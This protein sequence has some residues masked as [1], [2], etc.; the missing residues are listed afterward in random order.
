M[1]ILDKIKTVVIVILE[2][3][4]FDHMLG[5]LALPP[6]SRPA[7]DGLSTDPAWLARFTNLDQGRSFVPTQS[8]YPYAL[9][10]GFDPP[11]ERSNVAAQLGARAGGAYPMNSF[12]SAIPTAVSAEPETRRLVMSYFGPQ[13]VPMTNFLAS[14]FTVCDHW[15]CSLPA[16][17]QPNRLMAMSG[18]SMIEVNTTPIPEQELVYDWLT[19]HGVRWRVY[20]Q[21]IPFFTLM[22]KWI[23][24]MLRNDNFRSFPDLYRDIVRTPPSRMPQVI[25]VEP[26]YTDA[27]HL[28]RSTDDHAPSGVSDGQEFL[29]QVYNAVTVSRSFWRGVLMVVLYDEHGGF[30]DHVSP[31]PVGADAPQLGRYPRFESLGVRIPALVVSPFVKSVGVS[32]VLLD[33]TSVLKLLGEK[34][35]NGSY[36]GPV[37]ARGVRS[38]SEVL[39]FSNPISDPPAAPSLRAYLAAR[40]ATR[41]VTPPQSG[42]LQQRAFSEALEDMKR[43]G[44]DES[45]PKFGTLLQQLPPMV[46]P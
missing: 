20:H 22:P 15:F 13:E 41:P 46:Q 18:A 9:P 42:S 6:F 12:M 43:Q 21:G 11:H 45:H 37:D 27:P 2:N 10:A 26:T 7:V 31:P 44:A 35:G 4:S 38:L 32:N 17:T 24:A 23:P 40:P 29:M 19:Q 1:S 39:D 14:N 36:S 30:F 25:F 8:D 33:H 5:Y 3:R 28:G 16:G 34:F